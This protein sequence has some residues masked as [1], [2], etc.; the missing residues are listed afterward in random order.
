[1]TDTAYST[2]DT[3]SLS[4]A[5]RSRLSVYDG[6]EMLGRLVRRG[7][8]FESFD[9]DGVS[10]GVFADMKSAAFAIPARSAS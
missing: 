1:M 3:I 10:H 9:I 7:N 8:S 4:S 5:S 6:Q 2:P